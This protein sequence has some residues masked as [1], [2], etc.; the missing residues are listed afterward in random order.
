MNLLLHP[1]SQKKYKILLEHPPQSTL[2][3]SPSGS[4]KSTVLSN[5]ANELVGKLKQNITTI[6]VEEDKVNISIDAIRN[7][8]INLKLTSHNNRVIIID[9]ADLMTTE[10]QNS[11]LK[12]LEEPPKNTYFLLGA[13]NVNEILETIRSRSIIWNLTLPQK[14]Q[15]LKYFE[16]KGYEKSDIMRVTAI[17]NCRVGLISEMLKNG[18][19]HLLLKNI[20]FAKELLAD[21]K[22]TRLTK[23]EAIT[24][25]PE[26][27]PFLME[28]LELSCK[29][30]LEHSAVN[31][32]VNVK[33]WNNRLNNV[34]KAQKLL[35]N[36]VNVKLV[37]T[38]MFMVL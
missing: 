3:L 10:A 36:N 26:N 32:P 8:K 2:L 24:K 7:L 5:L 13:N 30:A 6:E 28:A 34:L 31:S 22:F 19:E 15:I 25:E 16:A 38:K 18:K 21:S 4:G 35:S 29:A 17:S 14:D 1:T 9:R 12:L 20:D 27:L 37:L 23:I 33:S 11:L